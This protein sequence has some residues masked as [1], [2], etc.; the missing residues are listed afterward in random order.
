MKSKKRKERFEE[1]RGTVEEEGGESIC[2]C[3]GF[4]LL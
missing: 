1:E 2:E 4:S 3:R